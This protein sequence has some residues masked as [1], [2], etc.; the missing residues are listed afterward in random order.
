MGDP[1][2]IT[3]SENFNI[4][5]KL[6]VKDLKF[7]KLF[8]PKIDRSEQERIPEHKFSPAA[9]RKRAG[10]IQEMK[11][12]SFDWYLKTVATSIVKPPNKFV[13]HGRLKSNSGL[14][15]SRGTKRILLG[16]CGSGF[17]NP[18]LYFTL[19]ETGQI[20]NGGLC[21]TA[22]NNYYVEMRRCIPVLNNQIWVVTETG[23]IK[24]KSDNACAMHVTDPSR[25]KHQGD[26]IIMIQKCSKTEDDFQRWS[27]H[28]D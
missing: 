28:M 14:C 12:K 15:A 8:A 10:F 4:I 6:W 21:M 26:Q 22:T 20:T 3:N 2:K 19:N 7:Q 11:C 9:V 18:S 5:S 23:E 25:L 24:L 1:L 13:Q 17:Y 16:D 27:F